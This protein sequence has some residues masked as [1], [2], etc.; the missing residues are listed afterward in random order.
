MY[1]AGFEWGEYLG[2][3]APWESLRPPPPQPGGS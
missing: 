2:V 3:S 1:E